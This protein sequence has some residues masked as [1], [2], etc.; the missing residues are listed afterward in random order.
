MSLRVLIL[1]TTLLTL[2]SSNLLAEIPTGQDVGS[3]YLEYK[4]GKKQENIRER[5]RTPRKTSPALDAEALSQFPGNKDE[6]Y[7]EEI[8]VQT[9]AAFR[10]I[11]L[12]DEF[13]MFIRKKENHQYSFQEVVT[14][15]NEIKVLFFKDEQTDVYI[16]VQSC[17]DGTLYINIVEERT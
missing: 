13:D 9:E 15:T 10:M 17:D 4:R 3:R 12:S 16:P 5:I 7:I 2:T 1:V 11:V 8:I 6:Y 14:L